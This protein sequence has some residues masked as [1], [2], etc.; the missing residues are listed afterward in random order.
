MN[1]R[2]HV[3]WRTTECCPRTRG[4]PS[5]APMSM[6]MAGVRRSHRPISL[7]H[8]RRG[9]KCGCHRRQIRRAGRDTHD[10]LRAAVGCRSHARLG[11]RPRADQ[12]PRWPAGVPRDSWTVAS[13]RAVAEGDTDVHEAGSGANLLSVRVHQGQ[14]RY[15]QGSSDVSLARRRAQRLLRFLLTSSWPSS[16]RG[17]PWWPRT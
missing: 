3:V 13:M 9:Q 2:F 16:R 14:S 1:N 7:A 6:L 4:E 11:L 8:G 15:V 5:R 17:Q 10:G 12:R